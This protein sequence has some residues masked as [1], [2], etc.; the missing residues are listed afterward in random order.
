VQ[1]RNA[2]GI[3][4]RAQVLHAVRGFFASRG[5]LEVLTPSLV[6]SPALEEHLFALSVAD[7]FL[8]TSPEFALKK[9]LA[10][11]LPRIYEIGPC[12]RDREQ[13]RWHGREFFMLEWYRVG[14]SL[15][16]LMDE[17]EGVVD[18]AA[19]SLDRPSPRPWRRVTV[20]ELFRE[21]TGLD[22]A[23]A[24]PDEI[25]PVDPD[26]FD[27]AFF[28]RWVQDV[29]PA[30]TGPT[31]ISEW[32]ASQSALAQVRDDGD[33]PVAQRFEVFLGGVELGNAFLELLDPREQLRR[34]LSANAAREWAG[35]APHP[36][37]HDLIDAVGR[38]PPTAGIA[39]G[40]DRLVA[41]LMGW[42]GIAPGRAG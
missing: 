24:A 28:R 26:S 8:R 4:A 16:D 10:A 12:W 2:A 29:E 30:I 7:G 36:V 23:S 37:D 34:F 39:V 9:V 13:G 27:D 21:V 40:L 38:M 42:D 6:P 3:R 22:L 1:A 11:G 20:R 32:P 14:A 5:Y 17:V 15:P 33:W 18:A 25:S 41:A 35:E 31:F 19:A